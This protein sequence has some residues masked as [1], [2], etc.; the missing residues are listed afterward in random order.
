MFGCSFTSNR[1]WL[2]IIKRIKL[3][4]PLWDPKIE[5]CIFLFCKNY[6]TTNFLPFLRLFL[7]PFNWI[8]IL[9]ASIFSSSRVWILFDLL[10][11]AVSY[12]SLRKHFGCWFFSICFYPENCWICWF[13]FST[14]DVLLHDG[15]LKDLWLNKK[16]INRWSRLVNE[17]ESI[18]F[19][20]RKWKLFLGLEKWLEIC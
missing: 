3:L 17:I 10:K 7:L 18:L 9:S 8:S 4:K 14:A 20:I 16:V 1:L 5:V 6:A 19:E 12:S 13:Q 15:C 2:Y 11:P